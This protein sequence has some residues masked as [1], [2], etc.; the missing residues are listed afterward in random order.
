V[1]VI[2]SLFAGRGNSDRVRIVAGEELMKT[3]PERNLD[4]FFAEMEEARQKNQTSLYNGF[5]RTIGTVK[6]AGMEPYALRLIQNRGATEKF[7]AM[8]IAANNNLTGLAD[9]I[10]LLAEDRSESLARKAR[11]TMEILGI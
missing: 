8:D 1:N 9:E 5:L 10:K 11:R 4:S 6:S 2:E 3:E 7:T